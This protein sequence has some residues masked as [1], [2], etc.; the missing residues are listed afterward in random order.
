MADRIFANSPSEDYHFYQA[1]V[2]LGRFAQAREVAQVIAHLLSAEASY[3]NVLVYNVRRFYSWLL[4][5]RD[6]RQQH[7]AKVGL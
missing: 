3:T 6:G 4:P 7:V 1:L 5:T 2:P